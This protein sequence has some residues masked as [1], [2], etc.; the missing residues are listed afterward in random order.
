VA[1]TP[2]IPFLK[3]KGTL[4]VRSQP[5]TSATLCCGRLPELFQAIF[6]CLNVRRGAIRYRLRQ[7]GRGVSDWVPLKHFANDDYDHGSDRH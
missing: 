2:A 6:K 1:L 4:A 3:I 7:R 5:P